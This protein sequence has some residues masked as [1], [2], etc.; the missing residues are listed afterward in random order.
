MAEIFYRR[1]VDFAH[2]RTVWVV[3]S[4]GDPAREER[5][6]DNHKLFLIEGGLIVAPCDQ[7]TRTMPERRR[8]LISEPLQIVL[9]CWRKYKWAENKKPGRSEERRVGKECRS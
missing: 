8:L 3:I 7:G 2:H 1:S 5:R 4:F 9:G 6:S